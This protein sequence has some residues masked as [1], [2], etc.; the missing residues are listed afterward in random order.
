MKKNTTAK[1]RLSSSVLSLLCLSLAACDGGNDSTNPQS[2]LGATRGT[3]Y[4]LPNNTVLLP[5]GAKVTLNG[6]YLLVRA[7]K[8]TSTSLTVVGGKKE[9]NLGLIA[10]VYSVTH[11]G[12]YVP[13]NLVSVSLANPYVETGSQTP[14]TTQIFVDA[15]N[16]PVG[17][18][19]IK[20]VPDTINGSR[21][22]EAEFSIDMPVTVDDSHMIKASYLQMDSTGSLSAITKAGYNA[23][24]MMVFAFADINSG[25]MNTNY[26]NVMQTAINNEAPGAINLLSI[27]G[28]YAVPS[29]INSTT[30]NSIINNVSRQIAAYNAQLS[31]GKI[32]GVDLDLENGIDEATITALAKGFKD[33]G[34]T[35][36]VAPQVINLNG[37]SDVDPAN[38]I[39]LGLSSGGN[40]N[41]YG[42]AISSGYVDYILA[43]TYNSGGWTVGGYQ[44]NQPQ[45]FSAI[46]QALNNAVRTDC[47][48]STV[49][50]IPRNTQIVIGE[51]SNAGASGTLN[52]IFSSNGG[53][54]YQQSEVLSQLS[55]QV[56]QALNYSNINGVMQW[57]LNND[58]MPNGWSDNYATPG[59]F[60]TQIFGAPAPP[61]LPYFILQVTNSGP[62][63]AGPFAYSSA[64]LVVNGQY[65]IFGTAA[66]WESSGMVPIA[67][68][69]KY[70]QWGTLTSSLNPAT[71]GVVD[72]MNLDT[73]FADGSSSF[74]TSQIIINGY[75]SYNS[76]ILSPAGQWS[77]PLGTN[78]TFKAGHSYN[79]MV[80]AAY[81]SCD[82][83]MIN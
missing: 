74:T 73:M 57:S 70:Q 82:I 37:G 18:Y 75:P 32:S 69:N 51:P 62:D 35:V 28:Q 60:S 31:G 72:S 25:S 8:V 22:L 10:R 9:K 36:S 79:L 46:A 61:A 4:V 83:T 45:F 13:T 11:N 59:A 53:I 6:N 19:L 15:T 34:F 55:A 29:S 50:C 33:K 52:N 78:Y 7:G 1:N 64:T 66:S 49:L 38:P 17:N 80:N 42:P 23:S 58:Y 30:V 12:R 27:G 67:P 39:N 68:G 71:P 43:Q 47:A 24:N 14:S 56:P 63:V 65:W 2:P 44:E 48:K 20:I 3:S 54:S 81:R 5:D 16:A 40:S 77:C 21:A 26:L 76:T 41:Q